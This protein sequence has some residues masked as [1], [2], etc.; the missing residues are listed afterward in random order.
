MFTSENSIT[1]LS[2]VPV[3]FIL[4]IIIVASIIFFLTGIA[5]WFFVGLLGFVLVGAIISTAW[6]C[7]KLL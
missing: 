4:D 5:P 7:I 1:I 6:E 2:G 3:G